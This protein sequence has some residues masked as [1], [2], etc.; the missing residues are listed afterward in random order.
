MKKPILIA[1]AS[2]K[3]GVGKSTIS[4]LLSSCLHYLKG[5]DVA[6]I[7]CDS[8]QHTIA[9]ERERDLRNCEKSEFLRKQVYAVFSKT[10]RR[11]YPVIA[12][13]LDE[14]LDTA[15][16]FVDEQVPDFLFFD[17]PGTINNYDVIDIIRNV[18]YVFCPMK[19]DEAV[20]ESGISFCNYVYQNLITTGS[21]SIR[22]I[23]AIWN[24]VN[25]RVRTNLYEVYDKFMEELN[26]KVMETTLP[27]SV[28]YSREGSDDLMQA[29]FR[30]TLM[31]PDR[32][33]LRGSGLEKLVEEF[34]AITTK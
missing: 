32:R 14:A 31:P 9:R 18:D 24:M 26:I 33:A 23:H 22:E 2:Q 6:V 4:I 11:A 20:L 29:P 34:L 5:Y 15:Q 7:D 25:S 30:S 27:D 16:K 10:Q 3:G 8:P 19:A 28:R 12:C 21:S 1:V 17:L 13:N